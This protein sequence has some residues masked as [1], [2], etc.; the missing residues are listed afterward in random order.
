LRD[1]LRVELLL[2]GEF[3]RIATR[4]S[5]RIASLH[6]ANGESASDRIEAERRR[7]FER[8][9]LDD[10]HLAQWLAGL[11]CDETWLDEMFALESVY[12]RECEMLLTM[13]TR[14]RTLRRLRLPL[15]RLDLEM[16]EVESREVAREAFL[17]VSED[18]LSMAEV[19]SDGRYPYRRAEV[20]LEDLPAQTQHQLLGAAAGE[21]LEPILQGD[22]F[23]LVR[24]IRKIEPDLSNAE[25]S[26]R[27]ERQ[28]LEN[29][30]SELAAKWVR[31]MIPLGS[32]FQE[33]EK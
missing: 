28:I 24:L 26:Q 22:G 10:T 29:H 27:V 25:V 31:W 2:G 20:V 19:A 4:L 30:F 23:Q 1:L 7:F 13:Q 17:C 15:T 6:C 3:D 8:F 5:W 14:E 33:S 21:V 9:Q 12:G 18:G 32:T 16:M 11:G